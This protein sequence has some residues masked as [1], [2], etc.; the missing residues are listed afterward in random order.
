VDNIYSEKQQ[1]LLIQS[2]YVSWAG[3]SGGLSF[4]ALAHVGLSYGINQPP[5]MPDV[6]V[7]LAVE[8]P[9]D[10]WEKLH[11]SYM[12][13][14]YDKPPE[15]VIELVS[16]IISYEADVKLRAYVRMGVAYLV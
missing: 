16:K 6:L 7:S 3:P 5:L 4:V 8:L 9:V 10:I 2:L 13:W 11:R 12:I 14:E 1:C 15:V